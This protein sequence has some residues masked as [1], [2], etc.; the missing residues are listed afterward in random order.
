MATGKLLKLS[1]D[2]LA[3]ALSLAIV[4][5]MPMSVTHTGALSH[6]KACRASENVRH[7][8]WA[9]IMAREGMT[10]PSMPFEGHNGLFDHMGAFRELRLPAN[11]DGTLSIQKMGTKRTPTE[12]SSQAAL[13]LI[14]EMRQWTRPEEIESIRYEMPF[15]G[16]QEIAD[17][18]KFDPRN[19]ETA[20][21]SMPYMLARALMDGD[22]YL[23]AFSHEKFMDPK[24]RDLMAR[25][26]FYPQPD[27]TGNAPARIT[28]RK[29]SGEERVWDSF[30]GVRNAAGAGDV[31]TP[32]SDEEISRKFDRVTSFMRVTDAQRDRAKAVWGNLKAVRDIGEAIQTLA[33]FGRPAAL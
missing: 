25:M 10:G 7:G 27:W 30:K 29:K 17:P 31:N 21:H 23:D 18:P 15:S 4:P 3:N 19:R 16:W 22:I 2:Q 5:H 8:V 26:T 6:W 28:I 9:A 20:D 11:A 14:P 1:E 33:T 12:G 32:M 24:A 13:E